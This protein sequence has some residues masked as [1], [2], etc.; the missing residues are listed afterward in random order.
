VRKIALLLLGC[1]LVVAGCGGSSGSSSRSS[2]NKTFKT[3]GNYPEGIGIDASDHVWIANRYTNNVTEL[4]LNGNVLNTVTVGA[5]PHGLKIDRANTGNI[6][7][8]NTA[9]GGPGAPSCP[10]TTTGTVTELAPDASV[11][12]TFCTGGDQPQHAEF[13]SSGNIWVTNQG[14]NT[15]AEMSSAGALINTFG[16]GE[17]PHAIA[18][19]QQGNFWIGNYSSANV[20]VLQADGTLLGTISDVGQQPTGN[21]IDLSGNL[22]QSVQGL[23]LV[24][25]FAAAPSLMPIKTEPVGIAPRGVTIDNNGN[26]FVAN[27]HSNDVIEFDS[28]GVLTVTFPVGECPENMAIDSLGDLWVTNACGSTVSVLKNV[29]VVIPNGDG[30]SNG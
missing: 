14:S 8:Q 23:D 25:V 12:G 24:A 5:R 29:A 18:R 15:V 10:G 1:M 3:G 30:D 20:T 27:Q 11:V 19:D 28:S 21:S 22:W 13:D 4:D 9:G 26:V 7:V 2:K 17:N 6:W 16:T